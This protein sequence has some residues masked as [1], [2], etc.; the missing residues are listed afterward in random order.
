MDLT[1]LV[2]DRFPSELWTFFGKAVIDPFCLILPFG[3]IKGI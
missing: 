1:Q 2:K 3:P